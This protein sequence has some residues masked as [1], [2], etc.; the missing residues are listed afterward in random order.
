[1]LKIELLKEDD[2]ILKKDN[3][4]KKNNIFEDINRNQKELINIIDK[5][6]NSKIGN[7]IVE[8]NNADKDRLSIISIIWATYLGTL[9]TLEN[10]Y[11]T[12]ADLKF[13]NMISFQK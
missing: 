10:K 1:M 13:L 4:N 6:I 2:N 5:Y 3:E 7:F 12:N 11:I 9:G 8:N